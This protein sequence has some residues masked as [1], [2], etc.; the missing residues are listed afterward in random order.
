MGLEVATAVAF[1]HGLP[2]GGVPHGDVTFENILM[3]HS[4]GGAAKVAD[5]ALAAAC[6]GCQ[7]S[8]EDDVEGLGEVL[9]ALLTGTSD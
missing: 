7:L 3:E 1:L 4:K 6:R 5:A 2:G 9:L 8:V